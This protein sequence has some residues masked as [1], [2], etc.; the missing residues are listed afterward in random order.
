MLQEAGAQG[1]DDDDEAAAELLNLAN[2]DWQL[3]L[4]EAVHEA[5]RK[6]RAQMCAQ[7]EEVPFPSRCMLHSCFLAIWWTQCSRRACVLFMCGVV[8]VSVGFRS[9][10]ATFR[11]RLN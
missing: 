7:V 11:R 1:G 9:R 3:R 8:T 2:E 10:N 5:K 6:M 4:E